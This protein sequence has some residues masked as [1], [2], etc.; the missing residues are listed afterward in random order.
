MVTLLFSL[1]VIALFF[2]AAWYI[3]TLIP[4]PPPIGQIVQVILV[5]ICL[6]VLIELLLPM[7]AW[8]GALL[9]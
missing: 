2:A 8:H 7:T 9:R 4:L 6:V 3:L 5:L 1:L